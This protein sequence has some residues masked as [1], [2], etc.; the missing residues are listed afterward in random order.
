MKTI[1]SE[2]Q[3]LLDQITFFEQRLEDVKGYDSL[4]EIFNE[5]I[6]EA[7]TDYL[8]YCLSEQNHK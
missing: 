3:T 4:E 8:K 5:R 2:E 7:R 1:D 6:I